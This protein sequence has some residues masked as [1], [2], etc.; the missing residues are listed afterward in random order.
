MMNERIGAWLM[1]GSGVAMLLSFALDW[2]SYEGVSGDNPFHYPLTG[3]MAWLLVVAVAIVAGLS[4]WGMPLPRVVSM[5]AAWIADAALLLMVGCVIVGGREIEIAGDV[6]VT[7][8]R[9]PGMWVALLAS[10]VSAAGG[11]LTALSRM[12]TDA[13]ASAPR[14]DA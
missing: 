6:T 13:A 8:D 2:S 10:I 4:L 12:R 11:T 3:G 9:G 14:V 1:A 5:A 7:V